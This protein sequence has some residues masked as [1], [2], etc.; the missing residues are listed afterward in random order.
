MGEHNTEL[1]WNIVNFEAI[2]G[3]DETWVKPYH[4][5]SWEGGRKW[6][7]K[8]EQEANAQLI[9]TAVNNHARLVEALREVTATLAWVAHGECR[10]IHS[11]PV[12]PSNEAQEMASTLLAQ[13]DGEP[14]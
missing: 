12:M 2:V 7:S 9:V 4:H 5:D 6:P 1:P 3:A 8:A 11:G 10:A 14:E 13:L